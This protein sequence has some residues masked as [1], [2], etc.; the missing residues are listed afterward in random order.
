MLVL[1]PAMV[2]MTAVA[3][4]FILK[5]LDKINGL[6]GSSF[7]STALLSCVNIVGAQCVYYSVIFEQWH[8]RQV[9]RVSACSRA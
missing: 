8:P 3:S 2:A 9:T 7:A 5:N 1:W 6:V 4:Y